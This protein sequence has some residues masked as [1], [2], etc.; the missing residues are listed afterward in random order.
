MTQIFGLI[1]KREAQRNKMEVLNP[2][3]Y[4]VQGIADRLQVQELESLPTCAVA[5]AVVVVVVV[6]GCSGRG[7][8]ASGNMELMVAMRASMNESISA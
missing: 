8:M 4:C 2:N 1:M 6:V 3:R 5:V 7:P